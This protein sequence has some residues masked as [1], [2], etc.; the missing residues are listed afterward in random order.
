VVDV[1]AKAYSWLAR[2]RNRQRRNAASRYPLAL[3]PRHELTRE[4]FGEAPFGAVAGGAGRMRDRR[5]QAVTRTEDIA[6]GLAGGKPNH[7]T[8]TT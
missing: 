7:S 3:T 6:I 4:T 5:S 2:R 8:T 1:L